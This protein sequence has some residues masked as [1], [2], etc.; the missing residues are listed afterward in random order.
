MFGGQR[1]F[2]GHPLGYKALNVLI[3]YNITRLIMGKDTTQYKWKVLAWNCIGRDTKK[4]TLLENQ[5]F[6]KKEE[7]IADFQTRMA[8]I[9]SVEKSLYTTNTVPMFLIFCFHM[10]QI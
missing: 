7:C 8:K 3:F 10:I 2:V 5:W 6:D 4:W 1:G 9:R